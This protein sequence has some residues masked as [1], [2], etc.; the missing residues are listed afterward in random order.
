LM[1][2][3]D[4]FGEVLSA[5]ERWSGQGRNRHLVLQRGNR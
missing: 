4:G 3:F 2:I 5:G 1:P